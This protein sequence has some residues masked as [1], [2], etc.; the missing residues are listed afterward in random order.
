MDMRGFPPRIHTGCSTSL[1]A[2]GPVNATNSGTALPPSTTGR[3]LLENIANDLWWSTPQI[4]SNK[5]L[6]QRLVPPRR[7]GEGGVYFP[8]TATTHARQRFPRELA[9]VV[10]PPNEPKL[11]NSATGVPAGRSLGIVVR[12]CGRTCAYRAPSVS[13]RLLSTHLSSTSQTLPSSAVTL[14][15]I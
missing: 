14:A 9:R 5:D 12:G 15:G 3:Q 6:V 11:T 4:A 13:L 8:S 2:N 7:L 1:I 10:E